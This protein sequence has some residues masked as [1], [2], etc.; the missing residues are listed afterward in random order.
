[1]LDG[2]EVAER[3]G[4]VQGP[5]LAEALE[6]VGSLN[7]MTERLGGVAAREQLAVPVEVDAPG[8]A[9]ALGEQLEPFGWWVIAP[10]ALL[11]LDAPDLRGH[12][13]ALGPVQPTVGPPGQR[14]GE[15]V[16][17]L[18]AKALEQHLRVAGRLVGAGLEAVEKQVRG[19]HHVNAAVPQ[20]E[21]GRQVQP[22]DDLL[23]PAIAALSVAI[24][25]DDDLVA[26]PGP[27]RRRLRHPVVAGAE[28]LIDLHRLEPLR[29][30]KLQV[31]QHPEPAPVVETDADRLPD[32]RLVS[33]Q[34]DL[35]TFGHLQ[36][37]LRFLRRHRGRG[38]R[39]QR[40][41]ILAGQGKRSQR[42]QGQKCKHGD[43]A[44]ATP[45]WVRC[46]THGWVM[47]P[48]RGK[49]NGGPVFYPEGVA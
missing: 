40:R 39:R 20:G 38:P 26:A 15:G 22:R 12:R 33:E 4:V 31:L 27:L 44:K 41:R 14:V 19:L 3:V 8:V 9:A 5:V 37:L 29:V 43:Y 11:K 25:Q 23:R 24:V 21:A 30:R 18:H 49:D 46:A 1:M 13:A 17:V 32:H 2:I 28:I 47:Q 6:V 36:R 48:L 45:P 34:L 35:Q 7:V 42:R 16:G 10:D